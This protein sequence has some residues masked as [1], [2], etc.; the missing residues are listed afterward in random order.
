M[1]KRGRRFSLALLTFLI[2]VSILPG[3]ALAGG[4][5]IELTPEES[6]YMAAH[7]TLR[8]GYVQDRIPVSFMDGNGELAGISRYIFDRIEELSGLN[9]EYVPLR[10]GEVTY[11][12]LMGEKFDLVTSVEYNREN[13]GARGIHMTSPYLVSRKVVVA[14]EGTDFDVNANLTVALSTGSQTV[15][16]VLNRI[17]PNF[18]IEDYDSIPEC[19][20]AVA[21]GKS[22]LLI[23]NQY[24]A[25]YWISKP[26]FERVGVVP[27][28]GLDDELCFSAVVDFTGEGTPTEEEGD[29]LVSILNKAIARLTDDEVSTF[30]IQAVMENQY[31][32]TL[33]DFAYRYRYA[34][35]VFIM[36]VVIISALLVLLWRQRVRSIAARADAKAK[37]Q[38]LSAMSHEIRT[39][40]NGLI[41]LNYL[42]GQKLDDK[43]ELSEY[44][45]KSTST[46]KY[47]L[48]LVNDILD[49]SKIQDE[50]MEILREPMDLGH[51][52]GTVASIL[53]SAMGEKGIDF[54]TDIDL[55]HP[56]ILCDEVRVEQVLMNLLDNTRKFTPEGGRVTLTARQREQGD[57]VVNTITVRDTGRGMGEEFQKH[58]FD[59]FARE[60]DSDTVSKGN[61]GT[62]LGLPISRSLARL[63]GG[64]LTFE[65][66][67]GE[68]STFHF[69]FPADITEAPEIQPEPPQ[70]TGR[71]RVLVAEDN[72]LNAEIM[73]ELLEGEGFEADLAQDG[74]EALRLFSASP[75]G[76]YGVIL[77]DILMPVMDG[78]EATRAIRALPRPDAG[79]VRI[80]ACTANSFTQDRDKALEAGMDDFIAKPVDIGKL[81]KMLSE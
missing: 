36:A 76:H 57:R 38:F 22:D 72:E 68:G 25:E 42:M 47:L 51:S 10:M 16:K 11:D 4:E 5:G 17:F 29:I 14:R 64:D 63:M 55:P 27:V 28:M 52:V 53:R 12:Y 30:T 19:F 79:S 67:K 32:Y 2:L 35:G 49:M 45:S 78:F 56:Y 31:N 61:Q 40:L 43:R 81:M 37:G 46:A 66:R 33:G 48:T 9:F 58:V 62:G 24:V 74:E 65:S 73:L 39:P 23:Q 20:S 26:V 75:E 80:I 7:P 34:V 15:K 69:T 71:P 3:A 70:S 8:V 59:S 77:M 18:I 41:G 21:E 1:K 54:S 60:L 13:L 44:L 6:A 50:R